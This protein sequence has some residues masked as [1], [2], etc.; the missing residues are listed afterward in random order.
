MHPHIHM[1]IHIYIYMHILHN[2]CLR[3]T[4][5]VYTPFSDKI[6]PLEY[7]SPDV[8][9]QLPPLMVAFYKPGHYR[10]VL[11]RSTSCSANV[12]SKDKSLN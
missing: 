3:R 5:L 11:H 1:H 8:S 10:A 4:V 12:I 6:S 7:T 9:M 2:K